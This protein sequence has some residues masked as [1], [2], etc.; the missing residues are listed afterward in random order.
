MNI[1]DAAPTRAPL[2]TG[3]EYRE[4]LRRLKPV[5][6]V[7]GR[8]VESVVDEP[9][10]GPGVNAL[11]YTYDFALDPQMAPLALAN[12]SKRGRI[13]NRMLH[14]NES[15]VS[16]PLVSSISRTRRGNSA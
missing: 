11:A 2:M 7:D 3:T 1:A 4:S 16:R 12:Q 9:A 13:V 8:Q 5:V 15:S 10:F 14:V 6:Y